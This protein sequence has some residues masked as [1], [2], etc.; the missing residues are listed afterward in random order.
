MKKV[1][2]R[3]PATTANLGPG[4]DIL[5]ASLSMYNE[6]EITPAKNSSGK[7]TILG[8]GKTIL[9]KNEKNIL[10]KAMD[11]VFGLLDIRDKY[12]LSDFNIKL[13][14]DIPLSSGLGSSS[15]A[16]AAGIMAANEIC[17]D[18]LSIGEMVDLAIRLESHPDNIVP[19]FYGGI[20]ISVQGPGNEFF[21]EKLPVAK[22]MKVVVCTPGFEL[23]TERSRN[24]LPLKY[25]RKDVVFNSSRIALLTKAF[26]TNDFSNLSKA[27]QDKLH[28]PYR[29][30][31]I[32]VM[33]E[34]IE[35]AEK[36]GAYGACLSGSGP[37]MVAFCGDKKAKE[38]LAVMTKIWKK[39]TV[40][41]KQFILD[42][43]SNGAKIIK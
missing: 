40:P 1:K 29:A 14:N 25:A 3:V 33:E 42:F 16:R 18:K 11:A 17:G 22:K 21:V 28:Q 7:F 43:E 26:C 27:M 6:V 34:I 20:C 4:F 2:V 41:V 8:E 24:I 35:A 31:L 10:W 23:A 36:A 38:V 37:S 13:K 30:K 12:K 19:A 5:G 39:E 32:P 15:A 9:P